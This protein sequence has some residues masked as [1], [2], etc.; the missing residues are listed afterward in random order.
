MLE[1]DLWL[2]SAVIFL[3]S[4]FALVLLFFP[5]GWEE[6]MRWW[7]LLGT[8]A[9]LV[10]SLILYIDFQY[11]VLE[12]SRLGDDPQASTLRRRVERDAALHGEGKPG[13][14]QDLVARYNWIPR[15]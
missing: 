4:V 8:A 10:V 15:F 12:R 7:T 6:W 14:S 13:D 11:G 3:P 9:T 2:M 5:R 1:T